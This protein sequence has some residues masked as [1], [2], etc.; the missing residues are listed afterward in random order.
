M[1]D[2]FNPRY[3]RDGDVAGK[4]FEFLDWD[5]AVRARIQSLLRGLRPTSLLGRW[6]L[7]S[8]FSACRGYTIQ[9]G[10]IDHALYLASGFVREESA[11][12]DADDTAN[13][14]IDFAVSD[15]GDRL[16]LVARLFQDR[17]RGST[18]FGFS[19]FRLGKATYV[20]S[21]QLLT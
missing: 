12:H 20:V 6:F 7:K 17:S 1:R 11:K 10:D 14:L 21:N 16:D 9:V 13:F 19:L 5:E 8:L 4:G 18:M 2:L 3:Q 15:Y